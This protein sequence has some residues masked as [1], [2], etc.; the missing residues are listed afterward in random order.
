MCLAQQAFLPRFLFDVES[1]AW[2]H[3]LMPPLT[4]SV[5]LSLL[6]MSS[7]HRLLFYKME[8]NCRAYLIGLSWGLKG[9]IHINCIQYAWHII[10]AQWT[11]AKSVSVTVAVSIWGMICHV[12]PKHQRIGVFSFQLMLLSGQI[13]WKNLASD[14]GFLIRKMEGI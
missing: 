12:R 13:F 3:I 1:E 9:T 14:G 2:I 7:F 11:L 6:L 8:I 5:T 4:T 10:I